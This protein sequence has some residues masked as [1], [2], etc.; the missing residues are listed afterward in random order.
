LG[1]LYYNKKHQ[2]YSQLAY[3]DKIQSTNIATRE[4]VFI[5][6]SS[7]GDGGAF[8]AVNSGLVL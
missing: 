6:I 1:K 2:K 7:P 4:S 3:D 5:N 8:Y